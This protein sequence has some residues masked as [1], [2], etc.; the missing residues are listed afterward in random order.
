MEHQFSI[1]KAF[2]NFAE[3]GAE[4]VMWL[5]VILGFVMIVLTI[6]RLVLF[7]RTRVDAPS[8]A[9]ELI[10][11]LNQGK[12]K[13]AKTSLTQGISMEQRVIADGLEVYHQGPVFVEQMMMSALAREKQ[14]FNRYL[15]YF[16]TLGNN[17]PFIGLFGTVIGIII[18][19]KQ[20]GANPKGGLEVIGPAISEALVATAV[21][22]LVAIPAVVLFNLFKSMLKIRL[23][24]TDY[25][26]RIILAYL[27]DQSTSKV[28]D[29]DFQP[30]QADPVSFNPINLPPQEGISSSLSASAPTQG[31]S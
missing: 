3:L 30:T 28:D 7:L 19:F 26:M 16:G 22:L 17:T 5:M 9:R 14:R 15:S 18:A 6:E 2:E 11:L 24:N 20:L 23:G 27:H 29:L 21:G 31:E 10:S 1:I 8:I 13:E 4:W 12:I 25:L